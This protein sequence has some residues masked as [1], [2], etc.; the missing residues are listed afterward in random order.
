[1]S[2]KNVLHDA[3]LGHLT[4]CFAELS[5]QRFKC[6]LIQ[7]Y[8]KYGVYDMQDKQ[9]LF[10]LIQSIGAS[11]SAT[12]PLDDRRHGAGLGETALV[13]LEADDSDFLTEDIDL[14]GFSSQGF[15]TSPAPG[16][17]T[18]ASPASEHSSLDCHPIFMAPDP[19]KIRVIVRK[20][21]LNRKEEERGDSDVLECDCAT[22]TLY[23]NEPKQK[24]DLTKFTER[25]T[26][27]FDDVFGEDVDN[28]ALYCTAIQPLIS[29]IFRRGKATCFAYGQTGSGKTYTMQPLPLRAAVDV[30]S[31]LSTPD[32]HGVGLHVSCYEIYGGKLFDLLNARNKLEVR[33][34]GKRRV[35]VV[36]LREVDVHDVDVLQQLVEHAAASRSTGSTGANDESSRSHSIMVFALR[37]GN[38]PKRP[39]V[40]KL[41]F[42]DLAGSERGADTYDNDKQTRLEGAE[43]NKS[44]LALK[45]CIRA[46]DSDA[47]HIPFRG[48]KLTEVL[49]DSFMGKAARTVMIANVSPCSSSCEHTLNTLRYADRVKEIRKPQPGV[50]AALAPAIGETAAQ[51]ARLLQAPPAAPTP[52]PQRQPGPA[53]RAAPAPAAAPAAGVPAPRPPPQ[54]AP[55]V[56]AR[57][58]TTR[59]KQ[60]GT[61]EAA[62]AQEAFVP[63]HNPDSIAAARPEPPR[64]HEAAPTPRDAPGAHQAPGPQADKGRA[65]PAPALAA[66]TSSDPGVA[67]HPAPRDP[68]STAPAAD[69]ALDAELSALMAAEDELVAAHRQHIEDSMAHVREEMALLGELD[70][71]GAAGDVEAYAAE[72]TGLLAEKAA[73]VA[74]LQLRVTQFRRLVQTTLERHARAGSG[75]GQQ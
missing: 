47:R 60:R 8:E 34:D 68:P 45:E 3:G 10:R 22:S 66:A 56:P 36:G 12:P 17:G 48:S 63:T 31:V 40:G 54:E 62:P 72:L 26:F 28:D 71:G 73:A 52:A 41:T 53:P 58:I 74:A 16:D 61:G 5:Y 49:R 13:D 69:A 24:V 75:A 38:E 27:R 20:R 14:Q 19:P 67:P 2:V 25:H 43:I 50:P 37:N 18:L 7:D 21:P 6:L 70:G 35:Q 39:V 51:L 30:L 64:R 11:E 65:P 55:L 9:A 33:E 46:L 1:M 42:I 29:T 57:G 15:M 32:F 23:V 4:P 59:S 44:L